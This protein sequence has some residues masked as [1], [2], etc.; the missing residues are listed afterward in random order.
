MKACKEFAEEVSININFEAKYCIVGQ[1]GS[2]SISLSFFQYG[3]A[4]NYTT[5]AKEACTGANVIVTDTW[6]SMG[7]EDETKQRLKD[8]EGYQVNSEV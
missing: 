6:V 7:Q 5:S 4:L 2:Y 8:F 1:S 3:T